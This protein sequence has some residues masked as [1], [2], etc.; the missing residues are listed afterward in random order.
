[1][2]KEKRILS[3]VIS[4]IMLITIISP[5]YAIDESKDIFN[6][7]IKE[8]FEKNSTLVQDQTLEEKIYMVSINAKSVLELKDENIQMMKHTR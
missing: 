6:E 7:I 1:M 5:S 3:L 2:K 4:L 8:D